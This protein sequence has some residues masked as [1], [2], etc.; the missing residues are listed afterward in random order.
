M[1]IE[2]VV[3]IELHSILFYLSYKDKKFYDTKLYI[4]GNNFNDDMK[5]DSYLYIRVEM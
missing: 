2:D 5:I 3:I 4:L 1:L